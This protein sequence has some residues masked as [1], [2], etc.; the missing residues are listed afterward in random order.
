MKK[1]VIF[2]IISAM[3]A[4]CGSKQP[5]TIST[6]QAKSDSA[7]TSLPNEPVMWKVS[8]YASNLGNNRNSAYVTNSFSMWGTFTNKANDKAELKVK[9]VVDKETFCIKL[10]EF[11]TKAVKKGDEN[12][13]KISIKSNHSEPIEFSAKNVSDRLFIKSIDSQKI[14]DCFAKGGLISFYLVTDSKTDPAIYAFT[15]DHPDGFDKAIKKLYE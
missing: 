10:L 7:S 9:F 1:L 8:S 6:G 12:Q 13:Y 5:K 3:I 4:A 2:L 14:I 15:I 11:G